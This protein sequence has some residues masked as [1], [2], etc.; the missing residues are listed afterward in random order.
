MLQNDADDGGVLV[1]DA[2]VDDDNGGSDDVGDHDAGGGD[3]DDN[4]DGGHV[5][6]NNKHVTGASTREIDV[7]DEPMQ[8]LKCDDAIRWNPAYSKRILHM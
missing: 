8:P 3:D 1:G 7:D 6:Q 4:G 2:N 5:D